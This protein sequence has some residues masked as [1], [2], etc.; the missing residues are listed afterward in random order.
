MIN[1][2]HATFTSANNQFSFQNKLRQVP[3]STKQNSGQRIVGSHSLEPINSTASI[4]GAYKGL[5]NE[6]ILSMLKDSASRKA[7]IDL[8]PNDTPQILDYGARS[9]LGH[10][11]ES[12]KS[13]SDANY[14]S[15]RNSYSRGK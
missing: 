9:I 5:H 13:L 6:S 8:T 15:S 2:N 12:L 4:G 7:N 11:Q 3:S 14:H 10:K 1:A